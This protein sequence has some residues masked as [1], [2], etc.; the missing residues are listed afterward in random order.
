MYSRT[1]L[2][3][4]FPPKEPSIQSLTEHVRTMKIGLATMFASKGWSL[5]LG[6]LQ[7]DSELEAEK[8]MTP[9]EMRKVLAAEY[10]GHCQ[11]KDCA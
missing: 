8:E 3:L 11:Y 9:F 10:I 6:P 5:K 2:D 7:A 4:N 1:T